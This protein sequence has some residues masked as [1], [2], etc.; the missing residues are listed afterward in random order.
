M[1]RDNATEEPS[2]SAAPKRKAGRVVSD[3]SLPASKKKHLHKSDQEDSTSSRPVQAYQGKGRPYR[4]A[5][6]E[7]RHPSVNELKR[8]VRDVKRLLNRVD[9][10]ADARIVQERALAG[11][12]KDLQA[13]LDR[14]E[15]SE[16]IKRY[17]FVRFLGMSFQFFFLREDTTPPPP[18]PPP[19]PFRV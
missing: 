6:Q 7:A 18:L 15:R 17:H 5:T 4:V 19:P 10:P 2:R 1:P 16:M 3:D 13:E 9:L 8:R 11:Y 12:E 14:R